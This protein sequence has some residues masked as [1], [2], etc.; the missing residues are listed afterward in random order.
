MRD[1]AFYNAGVDDATGPKR[2]LGL[3]RRL[4]RRVLRPMFYRQEAIYQELQEQIDHLSA[5]IQTL[6]DRVATTDAFGWDSVA[7]ARRMSAIEDHLA[8]VRTV[9]PEG[10]RV[11]PANA[12]PPPHALTGRGVRDRRMQNAQKIGH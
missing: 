12:L 11:D 7:M 9:V 3:V 8:S 4:I 5:Q 6:N 2:M 10:G 1:F